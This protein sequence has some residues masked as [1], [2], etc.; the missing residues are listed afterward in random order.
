MKAGN[1]VSSS[2]GARLSD[3]RGKKPKCGQTSQWSTKAQKAK[4]EEVKR[5]K[6]KRKKEKKENK[7]PD[8]KDFGKEV[9]KNVKHNQ[10]LKSIEP[11]RQGPWNELTNCNGLT[12]PIPAINLLSYPLKTFDRTHSA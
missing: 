11:L 12:F 5:E 4:K 7:S 8:K 6:K 10:N 9:I 3:K 1:K 2:F